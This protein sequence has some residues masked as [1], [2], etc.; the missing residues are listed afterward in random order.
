MP[1]DNND[2]I[3]IEAVRKFGIDVLIELTEQLLKNDKKASAKLINSLSYELKDTMPIIFL[4]L[5]GQDYFKF[6]EEGR[7]ASSGK[8]PPLSKIKTWCSFK[9]IDLKYAYP[10]AQKI[11][12]FGI[13]KTEILKPLIENLGLNF[14][15]EIGEKYRFWIE[16]K[17]NDI[18]N[19]RTE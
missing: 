17:L 18:I 5:T 16:A 11:G 8:Q 13:P 3:I 12:R 14:E 9:G 4:N 1:S 7:G 2:K 19:Q 10:I 6:I 15:K